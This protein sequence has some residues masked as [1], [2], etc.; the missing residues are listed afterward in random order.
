MSFPIYE[1]E[2]GLLAPIELDSL[3]FT[4]KR[5][6]YVKNVP[7]NEVRGKHAH[8][9][10]KQLLVCLRGLIAVKLDH[11]GKWSEHYL[12]EN[13]SV[14]CD[15]MVWDEQTYLT[16]DAILLSICSTKHDPA[17]YIRDYETFLQERKRL[18]E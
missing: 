9:K 10:T 18:C 17:D 3:P 15:E 11:G 2:R 12:R 14:F 8:Y 5:I 6:F 1:D 13:E 16:E 7:V 4:P